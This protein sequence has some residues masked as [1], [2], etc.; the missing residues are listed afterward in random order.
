[1]TILTP[2]LSF[3]RFLWH[4][5]LTGFAGAGF[6]AAAGFLLAKTGAAKAAVEALLLETRVGRD[7]F[8][9]TAKDFRLV[10]IFVF[11]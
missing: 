4:S 5:Y 10:D 3:L 9:P 8:E 2:F 6:L 1:M 7:G 11:V